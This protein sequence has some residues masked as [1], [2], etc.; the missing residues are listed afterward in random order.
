MYDLAPGTLLEIRLSSGSTFNVFN[1]R[2]RP[3]ELLHGQGL[4]VISVTVHQRDVK[5]FVREIRA[6]VLLRSSIGYVRWYDDSTTAH[7]KFVVLDRC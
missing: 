5:F 2:D 6:I 1:E 3:A 4:V 7:N